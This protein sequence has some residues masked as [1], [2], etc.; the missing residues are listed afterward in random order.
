M[1]RTAHPRWP[2][3][4]YCALAFAL[5][6]AFVHG[7]AYGQSAPKIDSDNIVSIG[8]SGY[9]AVS[10]VELLDIPEVQALVGRPGNDEAALKAATRA[11]ADFYRARGYM[12]ANA[13]I[14]RISQ[15]DVDIAIYEGRMDAVKLDNQSTYA[16]ALLQKFV[17]RALCADA[18]PQCA[19]QPLRTAASERMVGVLSDLPGIIGTQL[20][21]APGASAGTTQ[22]TVRVQAAP[23][24]TGYV[25]GDNY[26]GQFTGKNRV[27]VGALGNNLAG[28]GD[29]IIA[30]ISTSDQK[31]NTTGQLGASLP[32]GADGARVG[33][34]YSRSEYLLGDLFEQ[35][36]AKGQ[37]NTV[38]LYGLYP[39]IRT[40]ENNLYLRASADWGDAANYVMGDKQPGAKTQGVNIGLNGRL[41]DNLWGRSVTS[42]GAT[43]YHGTISAKESTYTGL[44]GGWNK[45]TW[46]ANRDQE[47]MT[48]TPTNRI[49]LYAALRG[50]EASQRLDGSQKIALGGPG[51]VRAYPGGEASG[52]RG[53]V[54]NFELRYGVYLAPVLP[55]FVTFTAFH[56]RGWKR[57]VESINGDNN[58]KALYGNGIGIN[59]SVMDRFNFSLTWAQRGSGS[60]PAASET[61]PK[62]DRVWM[63]AAY[64]F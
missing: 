45:L 32:V 19:D 47:L 3:H 63:Q 44:T 64:N 15:G 28:Q 17:T 46:N 23:A 33:I 30:E 61:T 43:W 9:H 34:T 13:A 22:P 49:S 55:G 41:V 62:R 8:F 56:D 5:S 31:G 37:S 21:L 25:S 39:I 18:S 42:Y 16:D 38:S 58:A 52:D 24:V 57:D 29:Q 35:L 26:G 60:A 6:V 48:P 2:A 36:D 11:I 4:P 40:Q 12:V 51:G 7:G 53:V 14:N 54:G 10:G 59:L 20:T 50:Q 27:T 1:R